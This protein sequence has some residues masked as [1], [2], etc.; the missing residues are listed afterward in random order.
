MYE[1]TYDFYVYRQPA[2]RRDCLITVEA[3][4]ENE[5]KEKLI[6]EYNLNPFYLKWKA[7]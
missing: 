6:K 4:D 7:M 5:L 3:K 2:S 1:V